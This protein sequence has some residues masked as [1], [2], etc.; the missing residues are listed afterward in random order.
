MVFK[1]CDACGAFNRE[2]RIMEGERGWASAMCPECGAGARFRRLPLFVMTGPSGA[3]KTTTCRLL[4]HSLP[5]CVV[6]ES[7][8]LW[9][10][11]DMSGDD[12]LRRYWDTWLRVV[13]NIHQAGRS[14]LLCGTVVPSVIESL[15]SQ[16]YLAGTHY[17][18]LICDDPELERRLRARP[19]W[20]ESGSD[21]F[22]QQHLT[23]N[24]WFRS[25]SD[26]A[27]PPITLID[28]THASGDET[29]GEVRQWVRE[30][31]QTS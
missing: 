5:E 23:F 14:V 22:I 30:H 24:Q 16:A 12:S 19:A 4:T 3:G 7:D 10:S 9:G 15:P 13:T 6:L 17:L 8:I 2:H 1:V 28:T 29:A 25:R 27:Q 11:I 20:R 26:P 31:L 21:D 18:A